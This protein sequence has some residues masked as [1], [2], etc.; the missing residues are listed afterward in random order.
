MCAAPHRVGRD[1]TF[2]RANEQNVILVISSV[3]SIPLWGRL[4]GGIFESSL[5]PSDPQSEG[6]NESTSKSHFGKT[7]MALSRIAQRRARR[8]LIIRPSVQTA[9]GLSRRRVEAEGVLEV[10]VVPSAAALVHDLRPRHDHA[11]ADVGRGQEGRGRA[12]SRRTRG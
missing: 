1:T 2:L 5:E 9:V 6:G 11:A 4:H 3:F 8:P 7:N 10:H 12:M